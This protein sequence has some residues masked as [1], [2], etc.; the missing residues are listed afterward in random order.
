LLLSVDSID[1][2]I[3]TIIINV[4]YSLYHWV[5]QG[6]IG[7]RQLWGRSILWADGERYLDALDGK[8][9][10]QPHPYSS[11]IPITYPGRHPYVSANP[12]IALEVPIQQDLNFVGV[13]ESLANTPST[14]PM[15]QRNSGR[16]FI[17][18]S[19]NALS[20][21]SQQASPTRRRVASPSSSHMDHDVSDHTV[22]V[23]D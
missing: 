21:E 9:Y 20:L 13:G 5:V 2:F 1:V 11:A 6:K 15:M 17:T 7:N 8:F 18:P 22:F 12:N 3:A 4:V 19:A 16:V 23:G 10:S 14:M